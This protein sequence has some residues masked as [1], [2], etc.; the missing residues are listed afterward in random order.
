MRCLLELLIRI[1]DVQ[2]LLSP[3][4]LMSQNVLIL[5]TLICLKFGHHLWTT[6]YSLEGIVNILKKMLLEVFWTTCRSTIITKM[7]YWTPPKAAF[8]KIEPR[9]CHQANVVY[10]L[11]C[12]HLSNFNLLQIKF[13]GFL[14]PR[15]LLAWINK[16]LL[17]N[18]RVKQK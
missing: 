18:C 6:P 3:S 17:S 1:L 8:W 13:N 10:V 15:S 5:Q 9:G 4:F 14:Q 12:R 11:A 2:I 7:V 16:K